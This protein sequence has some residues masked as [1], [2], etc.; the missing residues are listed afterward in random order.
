MIAPH[1]CCLITYLLIAQFVEYIVNLQEINKKKF[2]N[3][4]FDTVHQFLMMFIYEYS[5]SAS[6]RANQQYLFNN[7]LS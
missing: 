5:R 4:Y 2:I 1:K 6:D 3:A 7:V